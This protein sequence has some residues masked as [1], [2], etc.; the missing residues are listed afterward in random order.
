MQRSP[1]GCVTRAAQFRRPAAVCDTPGDAAPDVRPMIER[2]GRG[3]PLV[4][5]YQPAD[6][7]CEAG[8]CSPVHDGKLLFRDRHHLG[9]EGARLHAERLRG[10]LLTALA[11]GDN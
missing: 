6:A 10:L 9:V 7:V 5:R 3:Y 2:V 11:K 8:H 1:R 4:W